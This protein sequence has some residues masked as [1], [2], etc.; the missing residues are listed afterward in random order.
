VTV[1]LDFQSILEEMQAALETP[2]AVCDKY[3]IVLASSITQFSVNS[4]IPP[5]LLR[6]LDSKKEMKED[7]NLGTINNLVLEV[8]SDVLVFTFSEQLLFIAK[9][10]PNVNLN[11]F[12]PIM[13]RL[14]ATLDQQTTAPPLPEFLSY[15]FEAEYTMMLTDL[16]ATVDKKR[17]ESFKSLISHMVAKK[18]KVKEEE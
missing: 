9:I 16:Q 2:L 17:L 14:V 8:G 7:L 12:L 4:L 11:E 13:D 6:T 10:A 5:S 1:V 15:D 3:G 18:P